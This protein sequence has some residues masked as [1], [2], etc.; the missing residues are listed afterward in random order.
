MTAGLPK[1]LAD[2]RALTA[3]QRTEVED[4]IQLGRVQ[5]KESVSSWPADVALALLH[6]ASKAVCWTCKDTGW[7][8]KP[9]GMISTPCPSCHRVGSV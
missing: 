3:E 6:A 9:G 8:P 4:M 2:W 5:H 1:A 7:E